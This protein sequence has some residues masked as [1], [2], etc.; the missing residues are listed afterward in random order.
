VTLV[1]YGDF[2]CPYCGQAEPVVRALLANFGDLR[3][4]WRHLPL[5][6]PTKISDKFRTLVEENLQRNG[7]GNTLWLETSVEDPGRA[8]TRQAVAA[9]V[10]L[11]IGAGGDGTIRYVANGLPTPGFRWDWYLPA[12]AICWLE[13][14]IFHLRKWT[15]SRSPLT[16][17]YASWIW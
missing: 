8:M 1:E 9:Q 10:D 7:W 11:V 16:G 3:Y 17:R 15:P 14:W 6:N 12:P 2:E 4:V 13:T 5:Y